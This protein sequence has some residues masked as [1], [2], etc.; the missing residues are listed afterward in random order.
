M[1]H[2]ATYGSIAAC[3]QPPP[4]AVRPHRHTHTS[5]PLTSSPPLPPQPDTRPVRATHT[6]FQRIPPPDK[7]HPTPSPNTQPRKQQ[8]PAPPSTRA[9]THARTHGLSLQV[10][11]ERVA[12]FWRVGGWF[13]R[14]VG[15]QG[16]Q[17]CSEGRIGCGRAGER[18]RTRTHA[19][20]YSPLRA[21]A[22]AARG[23]VTAAAGAARRVVLQQL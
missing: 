15:H 16:G 11:L 12:L 1:A 3:Y 19:R 6:C 2:L 10:T 5:H 21:P 8:V 17:S 22:A 23:S 4:P 13:A 7:Q 20:T 9:H 18:A 14:L